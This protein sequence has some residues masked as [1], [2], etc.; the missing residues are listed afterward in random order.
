M[1][2]EIFKTQF[3]T[4]H[5]RD[6]VINLKE[7][8][9]TLSSLDKTSSFKLENCYA[10]P[11]LN[12]A[13]R[14]FN[15]KDLK[16]RWPHLSDY[17][18]QN[19]TAI[20][21]VNLFGMDNPAAH[22]VFASR[23]DRLKT[24]ARCANQT[25]FGWCLFGPLHWARSNYLRFNH[26]SIRNTPDLDVLF[27]RFCDDDSFGV[28]NQSLQAVSPE[29]KGALQI[30]ETTTPFAGDRYESGL[31][32]RSDSPRLPN[33]RSMAERRLHSFEC[34][35]KIDPSIAEKYS[36]AINEHINLEHAR[37]LSSEESINEPTGQTWW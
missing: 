23:Y 29:N 35:F 31:L 11:K 34:R 3:H 32:W 8:S 13:K 21:V 24:N 37:T 19:T 15:W 30:S 17:E 20:K 1:E 6:P 25:P 9:V 2:G 7:L 36:A 5:N 33:S 18:L 12:L 22:R 4:F 10:V 27:E 14:D 26:L 16:R 28:V